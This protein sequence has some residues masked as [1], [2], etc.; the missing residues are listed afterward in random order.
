MFLFKCLR[1]G[2]RRQRDNYNYFERKERAGCRTTRREV[3]VAVMVRVRVGWGVGVRVRV[4]VGWGW[5]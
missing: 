2:A 3:G 5:G 1:L 4:R